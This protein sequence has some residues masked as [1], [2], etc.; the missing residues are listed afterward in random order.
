MPTH[1][2]NTI[3]CLMIMFVKYMFVELAQLLVE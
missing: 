1:T 3:I 2:E